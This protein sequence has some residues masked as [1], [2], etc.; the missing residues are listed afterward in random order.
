MP[1]SLESSPWPPTADTSP[2]VSLI[3]SARGKG[4][5]D[6]LG[7]RWNTSFVWPRNQS[8]TLPTPQRLHLGTHLLRDGTSP[9]TKMPLCFVCV[10]H[11]T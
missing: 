1:S 4:C 11:V 2:M 9:G 10:K 6:L 3:S 8:C 5:S 7:Q